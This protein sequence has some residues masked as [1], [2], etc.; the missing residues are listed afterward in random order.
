ML[1]PER[2]YALAP[3]SRGRPDSG[4]RRSPPLPGVQVPPAGY[5]G[6]TRGPRRPEEGSPPLTATGKERG[7]LSAPHSP[8][9]SPGIW[10]RRVGA[11][12]AC[13]TA[14]GVGR[15]PGAHPPHPAAPPPR[16]ERRTRKSP[17]PR[18]DFRANR[19]DALT[20]S[21][22]SDI[23]RSCRR[24]VESA[25]AGGGRRLAPSRLLGSGEEGLGRMPR[26][27]GFRRA[28]LRSGWPCTHCSGGGTAG[29][30]YLR[31]GSKTSRCKAKSQGKRASPR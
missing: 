20:F 15:Q 31:E 26:G 1:R 17:R 25:A 9:W 8:R 12:A 4:P 23:G 3:H 29:Q 19:A 28:A 10:G 11:R 16:D 21:G 24:R 18:T 6:R 7:L 2:R 30:K 14:A 22:G 5:E 27:F 13:G